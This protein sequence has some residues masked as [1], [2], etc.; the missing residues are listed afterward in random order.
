TFPSYAP[1]YTKSDEPGKH[2]VVIGR[3]TQRGTEIFLN[4][5]LR[6]WNWGT[7]DQVRRWGENDVTSIV[8]F[9]GHDLVYATFDQAATPNES[10]LSNGDSGGAVFLDD[11]GVWKLAGISYSVDDLY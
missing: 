4:S 8:P 6:G 11:G 9:N 7:S 3:G 2:L 5:T 10:H 1:L